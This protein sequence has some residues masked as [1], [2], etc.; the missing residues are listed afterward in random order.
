MKLQLQL[1][2]RWVCA[3][4]AGTARGGS[5]LAQGR[6]ITMCQACPRSVPTNPITRGQKAI[7]GTSSSTLPVSLPDCRRRRGTPVIPGVRRRIG[8]P[9]N[10]TVAGFSCRWDI[11]HVESTQG[12]LLPAFLSSTNLSEKK[13]V[14]VVVQLNWC[15]VSVIVHGAADLAQD[16]TFGPRASTP[17]RIILPSLGALSSLSKAQACLR[18]WRPARDWLPGY[19]SVVQK[20]YIFFTSC[21][22]VGLYQQ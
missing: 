16:V 17:S 1:Q 21:G 7:I 14:F 10:C 5:Q 4:R 13:F 9:A 3:D 15:Q 6:P 18:L 20:L 2:G 11:S 8:V 22:N 19:D 12:L